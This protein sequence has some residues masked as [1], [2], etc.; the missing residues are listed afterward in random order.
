MNILGVEESF[1]IDTGSQVSTLTEGYY[2][3]VL[4]PRIEKRELTKLNIVAAN[5]LQVPYVGFVL[6][7]IEIA[8]TFVKDKGFLIVND[9]S[10]KRT[11]GVIG[12]NIIDSVP[13]VLKRIDPSDLS[14]GAIS[15]TRV[16]RSN[17]VQMSQITNTEMGRKSSH[18]TSFARVAGGHEVRIPSES[19]YC[20]SVYCGVQTGNSIIEP[21]RGLPNGLSAGPVYTESRHCKIP[22]FNHSSND[23]WLKPNM[24]LGIV[25]DVENLSTGDEVKISVS[26]DTV[27]IRVHEID[28]HDK[29]NSLI[30]K[31]VDSVS[32]NEDQRE[33]FRTTLRKHSSA[34]AKDEF[35]LGCTDLVEHT[36]N[37][38][39]DVPVVLPHRKVPPH[40]LQGLKEHIQDLLKAG[41]IKESQSN[42][43]SPIVIVRKRNGTIRLCVDFRELNKKSLSLANPLPRIDDSLEALAGSKYYIV[44]DLKKAYH[45][46]KLAAESQHKAAFGT[47]LGLFEYTRLPMGIS[48]A[49]AAFQ[50]LMDKT[51][52][53]ELFEIMLVYLDDIIIYGSNYDQ[54]IERL[55]VVLQR[56]KDTGLK[57]EL[58]KCQFFKEKVVYLGHEISAEGI[59]CDSGKVKAIKDWPKP[60]TLR[61]VRA[62]LGFTSYFRRHIENFTKIA[63]SLHQLVA[64]GMQNGGKNN[65]NVKISKWWNADCDQ[66]FETLKEKLITAPVLAYPDYSKEFVV[67]CDACE[68]GIAATL[69][70]VGDDGE[71]RVVAYAS[72]GLR[73]GESNKANY[74]SAKLELLAMKWAITEAFRDY[75]QTKPFTVYTDSNA[76]TYLM[77]K[78]KLTALEQR[79][80]NAMAFFDFKIKFLP[81]K[82]NIPADILSRLPRHGG[83]LDSDQSSCLDDRAQGSAMPAELRARVVSETIQVYSGE[84]TAVSTVFEPEGGATHLPRL[85][86]AE[87]VRLQAEDPSISRLFYFRNLNKKPNKDERQKESS[88]TLKFVSEWDRIVKNN[89]LL[90]RKVTDKNGNS[91]NQLLL[92]EILREEIILQMHDHSAHQGQERTESNVRARCYWPSITADVKRH[93][94]NCERCSLAKAPYRRLKT[95]LG[96]LMASKPLELVCMDFTEMEDFRG[97][98]GKAQNVLVITDV[99]TKFCITIPTR[100]QKAETVAKF[101]VQR[102]FHVY[103]PPLRLHSDRGGS[104]EAEVIKHLCEL[105]NIRKSRTTSYH[106]QGNGQCERY[107][108]TLHDMLRTLEYKKKRKWIEF[109]DD[110]TYQYNSSVHASTGFSPFFLMFGR[111]P[112]S[113]V[114]IL[115]GSALESA[116]DDTVSPQSWV[117]KHLNRLMVAQKLARVQMDVKAK[118]RK[119]RHDSSAKVHDLHIG[120]HGYLRK[121]CPGK[122]KIGDAWDSRIWIVIERRPDSVYVVSPEDGFG[123]NRTITR[124]EFKV[125]SRPVWRP[126]IP[127]HAKVSAPSRDL[128]N[129]E[130][131]SDSDSDISSG[132][133]VRKLSCSKS[134][135]SSSIDS[136]NID[137]S[138][139]SVSGIPS[140]TPIPVRRSSRTS[141]GQHSNV[142]NLPKSVLER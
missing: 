83:L 109:L 70:Q 105:Y 127:D 21:I 122:N 88:E 19:L 135:S 126:S 23:V 84:T 67:T 107:N 8:G 74:S 9:T 117:E 80:V 47:P 108:R 115:L 10:G 59:A 12:M 136:L 102:L 44:L 123:K 50:A 103:G 106:P 94:T 25:Q 62:Y 77:S 40:E 137:D 36:I 3:R 48:G 86:R 24:K 54:M 140:R 112:R 138:D 38:T 66:A 100:N 142:H 85:P 60:T 91:V 32:L 78:K 111:E 46:M 31:S 87:L 89:G 98:N 114:D 99:F 113:T 55:D 71:S 1:L 53:N 93:I 139:N 57:I 96:S 81:G 128:F 64:L 56:L 26:H 69:S 37:T 6:I 134:V 76:L 61:E 119:K 65:K 13:G 124:S 68:T 118:E 133:L 97:S 41:I 92:P 45:Q 132:I 104:F 90:Y 33:T 58:D 34:I 82:K 18:K 4:A 129:R 28:S 35:D 7:D 130:I 15:H 29:I 42:Y 14:G 2:N 20:V 39:D 30:D 95:P 52:R 131:S 101:L 17:L 43:R 120:T 121:R 73:K 5:G 75:L 125:C 116:T 16:A 63:R 72:R 27:N 49:P 51:F 110:V 141:K 11:Q 79:W 22:I